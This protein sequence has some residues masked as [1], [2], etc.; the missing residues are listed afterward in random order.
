MGGA[1]VCNINATL[2]AGVNGPSCKA[3][4]L[5]P[6]QKAIIDALVLANYRP[7]L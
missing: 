2:E 4:I 1:D 7:V 6:A 5:T 3:A